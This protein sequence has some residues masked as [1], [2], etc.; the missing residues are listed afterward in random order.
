MIAPSVLVSSSLRKLIN[1]S[2]SFLVVVSSVC[3][4]KVFFQ[5]ISIFLIQLYL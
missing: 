2:T 1:K 4:I 3:F 5:I